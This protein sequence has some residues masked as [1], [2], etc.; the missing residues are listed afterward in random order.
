MER[1]GEVFRWR[2]VLWSEP[3]DKE[4]GQSGGK[5][6]TVPVHILREKWV[7]I[8]MGLPGRSTRVDSVCAWDLYVTVKRRERS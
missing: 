2:R 7:W 6:D 1:I 4:P 5:M 8:G 3:K